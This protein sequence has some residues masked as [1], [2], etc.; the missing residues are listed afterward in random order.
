MKTIFLHTHGYL[1]FC[2]TG[3]PSPGYNAFIENHKMAEACV[4]IRIHCHMLCEEVTGKIDSAIM[5]LE[6]MH[7]T[8][9]QAYLEDFNDDEENI[10]I[11]KMYQRLLSVN[12]LALLQ[13]QTT[14]EERLLLAVNLVCVDINVVNSEVVTVL[15]YIKG[16]ELV[17]RYKFNGNHG[18][19]ELLYQASPCVLKE[20]FSALIDMRELPSVNEVCSRFRKD[21]QNYP[22]KS[23]FIYN[24]VK[25]I[26]KYLNCVQQ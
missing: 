16:Y 17:H 4:S 26:N 25:R 5:Q 6:K 3:E 19:T 9:T 2:P 11:S 22:L 24:M 21:W 23:F 1:H 8:A 7:A 20:Q 10:Y 14:L 12:N 15:T 18:E 13:Q